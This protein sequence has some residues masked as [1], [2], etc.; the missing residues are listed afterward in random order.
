VTVPDKAIAYISEHCPDLQT[1][2][3]RACINITSS[4][5]ER[6]AHKCNALQVLD[7]SMLGGGSDTAVGLTTLGGNSNDNNNSRSTPSPGKGQG[8]SSHRSLMSMTPSS[9]SSAHGASRHSVSGA[10]SESDK[11]RDQDVHVLEN[12]P[13]NDAVITVFAQKCLH[14][15]SLDLRGCTHMSSAGVLSLCSC[16][17]LTTLK[18][19]GCE[20]VEEYA[21]LELCASK[22]PLTQ[23]DFSDLDTSVTDHVVRELVINKTSLTKLNLTNAFTVTSRGMVDIST[24]G[25]VLVKLKLTGCIK[26]DD[27]GVMS[28]ARD[29]V[30]MRKLYIA[31]C[32]LL[33]DR[34][35]SFFEEHGRDLEE[36]DIVSCVGTSLHARNALVAALP[37]VKVYYDKK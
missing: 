8:Y 1:L 28:I 27:E 15:T 14:L 13:V 21:L 31:G 29:C 9:S 34:C 26:C 16:T 2:C 19:A 24:Y 7:V 10:D 4:T 23:A 17:A 30:Y 6:I 25:R 20:R 22:V 37:L 35:L 33:T 5:L 12:P 3:V 18:L 32:C 11:N 36:L